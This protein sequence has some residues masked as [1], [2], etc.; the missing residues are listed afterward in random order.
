MKKKFKSPITDK[1]LRR[2]G[3]KLEEDFDKLLNDK[4]VLL[5]MSLGILFAIT[6][7][8]W[9]KWFLNEPPRP[10]LYTVFLVI[11]F[12]VCFYKFLQY[13]KTA[14]RINQGLSGE[15]FIAEILDTF[16]E[17]GCKVYHDFPIEYGNI[18]HIVVNQFGVFT[19]ET[20]TISK[21]ENVKDNILYDG[22]IIKLKS[23]RYIE[24]PIDQARTEAKCLKKV[25]NHN[26]AEV[27][28]RIQPIVVYPRWMVIGTHYKNK[29][30]HTT[31]VVNQDYL[32]GLINAGKPILEKHEIKQICNA[33][34]KEIKNIA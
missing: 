14:H 28:V 21:E 31:W 33:I 29:H 15:R 2:P 16:K 11:G 23:G 13:K 24:N 25:L 27:K 6:F 3:Q 7:M 34:E 1:R 5:F 19:I 20:K 12:I 9:Y 26:I 4:L 22:K 17:R 10:I 8:E 32:N 30:I 18:D